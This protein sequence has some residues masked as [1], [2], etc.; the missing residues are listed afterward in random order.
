MNRLVRNEVSCYSNDMRSLQSKAY[1]SADN[2]PMTLQDIRIAVTILD[3]MTPT[4]SYM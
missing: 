3:A 4:L 1:K 2:P